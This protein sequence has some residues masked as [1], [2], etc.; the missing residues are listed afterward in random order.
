V[1]DFIELD[2]LGVETDRSGD[3]ITLRYSV[4]GKTSVH[5]VDGVSGALKPKK[6]GGGKWRRKLAIEFGGHLWRRI[7][8]AESGVHRAPIDRAP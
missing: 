1:A 2:F 6:S 5:V 8:A 4:N 7:L 3:A